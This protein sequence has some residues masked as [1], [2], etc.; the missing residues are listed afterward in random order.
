MHF[1]LR[2]HSG[3]RQHQRDFCSLH[4]WEAAWASSWHGGLGQQPNSTKSIGKPSSTWLQTQIQIISFWGVGSVLINYE[5][6]D[7]FIA[8]HWTYRFAFWWFSSP[9]LSLACS[10][11]STSVNWFEIHRRG[12]LC[13]CSSLNLMS[14]SSKNWLTKMCTCVHTHMH[15]YTLPLLLHPNRHNCRNGSLRIQSLSPFSNYW[16]KSDGI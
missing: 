13:N 12:R 14:I 7:Q 11:V 9:L 3:L 6:K 16:L 15:I 5:M 4:Q 10:L 8:W 2:L 1:V